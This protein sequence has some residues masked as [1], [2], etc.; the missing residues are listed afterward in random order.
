MKKF[1]SLIVLMLVASI[2]FAQPAPNTF[3]G[4]F[5]N[6]SQAPQFR[7]FQRRGFTTNPLRFRGWGGMFNFEEHDFQPV[8][9]L[10]TPYLN[11]VRVYI[12][13]IPAFEKRFSPRN[14]TSVV[15]FEI[16]RDTSNTT[17]LRFYGVDETVEFLKV[18]K[19]VMT[20][21]STKN[22]LSAKETKAYI[23]KIKKAMPQSV[24][25]WDD[26]AGFNNKIEPVLFAGESPMI[27]LQGI[28]YCRL[29]FKDL[30]S[31]I[32]PTF[33]GDENISCE[34]QLPFSSVE[35]VTRMIEQLNFTANLPRRPQF[36]F[37]R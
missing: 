31:I 10:N 14:R 18:V 24:F 28:S 6:E 7:S 37:R 33:A 19:D 9:R 13:D 34:I 32:D 26:Y 20:E 35:E 8:F 5:G 2:S 27:V 3:M 12:S 1:F 36:G 25:F 30:T 15:T 21:I 4:G 11:Q 23:K 29:K 16:P 22:K 17:L